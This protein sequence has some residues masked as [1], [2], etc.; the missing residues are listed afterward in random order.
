MSLLLD[1]LKKSG[2]AESKS[3]GL[4]DMQ[5]EE[6][7]LSPA[8]QAAAQPEISHTEEI[9]TPS[10]APTPPPSSAAQ[11]RAAGENLFAAKKPKPIIKKRKPLG[12]VPI[13]MM[14]GGTFAAVFGGYVYLEITPPNQRPFYTP[15]VAAAPVAPPPQQV[16]MVASPPAPVAAPPLVALAPAATAPEA[17]TIEAA[18]VTEKAAPTAK[19]LASPAK[20]KKTPFYR[21]AQTARGAGR[22]LEIERKQEVSSIDQ[23][24]A[25]AYQ[26]YQ[27]GD[28]ANAWQ[29]Y[30]AALALNPKNRDALLGLAA[31]SQ[32]QGQDDS[33]LYYYRQVLALDPRDP[34]A[35]A[36]LA[37]F[38]TA[39][40]ASKESRLKQLITQQP[41]SAALQ[42]SLGNQYV[43]QSRWSDAQQA[44]F[45]ALAIE[46]SNA[47]FA[48][49]LA[50]SLDHLGQRKV[51]ARYYQQA[52]QFDAAGNAGFDHTQA[53][54]RLNE[55]NAANR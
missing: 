4:A 6:I 52:L 45:N 35:Q 54:R 13:A 43:T 25:S 46:P 27:S 42:F 36:G 2:A 7:S 37:S 23:T 9:R 12:L 14:L 15:P 19:P 33:A 29:R 34:V 26:A 31:I 55:L 5:M 50:I 30:R 8:R 40:S 1:A 47:L 28:Y 21:P 22:K 16:A 41:D 38:G 10:R 49:N 3:T 53:Q 18:P 17:E 39:D 24:L 44:Y 48:Y 20:A 11:T 32:Q 51:A